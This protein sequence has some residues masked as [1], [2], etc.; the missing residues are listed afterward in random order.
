MTDRMTLTD[1]A[2]GVREALVGVSG[3]VDDR[4][5]IIAHLRAKRAAY[6]KSAAK[7]VHREK[8]FKSPVRGDRS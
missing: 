4:A 3:P 2:Q 5:I 1:M 7:V 6:F 8:P